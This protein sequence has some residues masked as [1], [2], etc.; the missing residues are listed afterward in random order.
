MTNNQFLLLL[1][2]GW[3]SP[4]RAILISLASRHAVYIIMPEMLCARQPLLLKLKA[5]KSLPS[6]LKMGQKAYCTFLCC[7]ASSPWCGNTV[8]HTVIPHKSA[9]QNKTKQKNKKKIP[10]GCQAFSWGL[11][12]PSFALYIMHLSSRAYFGGLAVKMRRRS[13]L[14]TWNLTLNDWITIQAPGRLHCGWW[15]F[16]VT[17]V[18]AAMQM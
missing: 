12:C 14:Q 9:K 17:S 10:L 3:N 6:A 7:W 16:T 5:E 4:L 2:M 8:T 1:P 11:K 15:S 18:R 13:S